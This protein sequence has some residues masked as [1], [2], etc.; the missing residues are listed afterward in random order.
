MLEQITPIVLT[1]NEEPNIGRTLGQLRWAQDIVLIDS[2]STDRTLE[3]AKTFPQV[4]VFQRRFDSHSAQWNYAVSETGI[5]TP[6]I[7]ALDADYIVT[8]EAKREIEHL[9]LDDCVAGYTVAFDYCVWGQ[10]LRGTLYPP[11]T[12]LYRREKGSYFQ[13]GHTHRL[14]L[15]GAARML[16]ARFLHDDRKSLSHWLSAQDR[17]MRLEADNISG[18]P[19]SELGIAD[20]I[21]Q[22]PLIAPFLV[23]AKC[24]LLK[25]GILDGRAGLYYALQRMLAEALL[26]LRMIERRLPPS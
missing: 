19:W 4:R 16:K 23:F 10:P 5:N 13:D 25:G 7:L 2:F 21:R 22:Y 15:D 26:G 8:D 1:F 14:K 24:Y 17:Y 18:K 20:R 9:N 6:W 12:T 11:V 3:I